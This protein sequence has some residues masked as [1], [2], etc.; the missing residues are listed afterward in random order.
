MI[1]HVFD[2]G[3]QFSEFAG[4]AISRWAA[5]VLRQDDD[6]THIVCRGADES[7]GFS[8][9]RIHTIPELNTY[10]K[11]RARRFYPTW[12][13]GKI[14]RALY[15]KRFPVLAAGDLV[16]VHGQPDVALALAPWAHK[17]GA[18]IAFHLHSSAF[19]RTPKTTMA[20][21]ARA[22]D[23][24]V[25]CS[26]FLEIEAK[27]VFPW[28]ERYTVL[29]NGASNELFYPAQDNSAHAKDC[30]TILL[31]CRLIPDK[32]VHILVEAMR[33]LEQKGVRAE[34]KIF[35]SSGFGGSPTT[36]YIQNLLD[37]APSNVKFPG[38]CAGMALADEFRKADIFCLPSVFNDPF[39][40]VVL[41]AMAARLPVV[42]SRRGGI[43]EALFAGGGRLVEYNSPTA[44]AGALEELILNADLRAKLAD[45]AYLSYKQHFTWEIV[46]R[47]YRK[48]VA[49]LVEPAVREQ[50]AAVL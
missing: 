8:P 45:E 13:N 47:E 5:N 15:K 23:K 27:E 3:E 16:W 18:K 25:F 29:Y 36:P 46:W 17:A 37:N 50:P 10:L 30:P 31:A 4:G 2:E 21:V 39:P 34:A 40:L 20:K 6:N 7:W 1:Y 32:G 11:L 48:I 41:E 19:I 12:L 43:P 35:G 38:Y 33:I 28:L 44:L 49:G 9:S 26:R 22:M 42:A 14:L 24:V